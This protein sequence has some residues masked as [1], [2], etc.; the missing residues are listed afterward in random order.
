MQFPPQFTKPAAHDSEQTPDEQ[1]FPASHAFPHAPQLRLSELS[2][3]QEAPQTVAVP[4][5]SEVVLAHPVAP[6]AARSTVM[7]KRRMSPPRVDE[8][9]VSDVQRVRWPTLRTRC[10]P[11]PRRPAITTGTTVDFTVG[12]GR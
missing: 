12:R 3:T 8:S 7:V 10:P 9:T 1:T 4:L 5:Q 6:I 11:P 2:S